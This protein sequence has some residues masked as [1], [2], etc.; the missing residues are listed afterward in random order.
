[1]FEATATYYIRKRPPPKRMPM[2]LSELNGKGDYNR[3]MQVPRTMMG[4]LEQFKELLDKD[5]A[6]VVKG[7]ETVI[8]RHPG[9]HW[10]YTKLA[11]G[12]TGEG[13][14]RTFWDDRWIVTR[15]LGRKVSVGNIDDVEVRN[16][17]SLLLHK[18]KRGY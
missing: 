17:L 9:Y 6:S 1:M 16:A 3:V 7:Q 2:W 8:A 13:V 14:I 4:T 5:L 10:L 12:D 11:L 18:Y 15:E